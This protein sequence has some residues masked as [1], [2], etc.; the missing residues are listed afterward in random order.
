MKTASVRCTHHLFA[1]AMLVMA[2][3]P[4]A[5]MA[6]Q[7]QPGADNGKP[8]ATVWR[9]RGEVFATNLRGVERPLKEGGNV[10][11]GEKIRSTSTGEAVLRT[12]DGGMVAIRPAASFVP[13]Q[14]AAEGK[15]TDRQVL[16]LISGSLRLISG[17]IARLN[18]RD[19]R[20]QTPS[21][22]IGIRGTDH[23]PYVLA[24]ELAKGNYQAGT[25]DKVNRG[26][27][28][29]DT[30]GGSVD[31]DPGRVGFA[32]DP[33]T[34]TRRTRALMTLLLPTLLDRIPDF[35][36]GGAFDAE[37]DRYS[38]KLAEKNP[39]TSEPPPEAAPLPAGT[40]AAEAVAS[41]PAAPLDCTPEA[42]ADYWLKRLDGAMMRRDVRTILSL[43][44]PEV[45]TR[46][47]V[48]KRDNSTQTEEFS[49]DEMVQS[50]LRSIASLK[51]Y[52]QRRLSVEARAG[53]TPAG[54]VC[55]NVEVSSLV[56]EQGLLGGKPYRFE[57]TETYQLEQRAGEWLAIR[58]ETVQ[59]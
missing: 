31:I 6:Q 40:D 15:A 33:A 58:A 19:H 2:C 59:R 30:D 44:A 50:T 24:P 5:A 22:T 12:A 46:A 14:F 16:R 36:I 4:A 39:R 18:P 48:R 29:L 54:G 21:A 55:P 37:L 27:T 25:Y 49:R 28:S 3:L 13:V 47:T 1:L 41:A 34:V 11:V 9:V 26:G 53:S 20:V 57:S 10:L 23:E 7:T 35:Y 32:R 52:H 38:E 56:I 8:F 42:V 51:N 45:V 17:W 43:F